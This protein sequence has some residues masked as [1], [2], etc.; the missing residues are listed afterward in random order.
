MSVHVVS[1]AEGGAGQKELENNTPS[2]EQVYMACV[3]INRLF[4]VQLLQ[5][6]IYD[7]SDHY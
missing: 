6:D 3:F 2:S 5:H 1:M 7:V 4:H